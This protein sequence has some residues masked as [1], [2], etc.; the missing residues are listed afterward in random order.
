MYTYELHIQ[1]K[2]SL[3]SI[4]R[5]GYSRPRIILLTTSMK[6]LAGKWLILRFITSMLNIIMVSMFFTCICMTHSWLDVHNL[7]QCIQFIPS[8]HLPNAF[9][10]ATIS[11]LCSWNL[12]L[13]ACVRSWLAGSIPSNFPENKIFSA[14]PRPWI[15]TEEETQIS[16]LLNSYHTTSQDRPLNTQ[17]KHSKIF[18]AQITAIWL[19]HISLFAYTYVFKFFATRIMEAMR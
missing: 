6:F 12:L 5:S 10:R 9:I 17:S 14:V 11:L 15:W 19:S 8:T 3:L 4:S 7:L 2:T 16:R 13:L 1:Q 18:Q